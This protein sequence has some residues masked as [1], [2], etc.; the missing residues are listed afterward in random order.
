MS[1]QKLKIKGNIPIYSL[2]M[3]R[4][5]LLVLILLVP[6]QSI[7][8]AAEP[9]CQHDRNSQ[10]ETP[11][12]GLEAHQHHGDILGDSTDGADPDS[13]SGLTVADHDH[14]CCS[15]ALLPPAPAGLTGALPQSDC[16][17]AAMPRYSFFDASRIERPKWQISP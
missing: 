6:L 17:T 3:R 5:V 7:W 8:A 11:H 15:M 4:L 2:A 16:V 10:G 14:H 12:A 9:Y 13:S 1:E